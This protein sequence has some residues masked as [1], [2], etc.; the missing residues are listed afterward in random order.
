M[1]NLTLPVIDG[2]LSHNGETHPQKLVPDFDGLT[3]EQHEKDM[4]ELLLGKNLDPTPKT[5]EGCLVRFI[6]TISYIS[7]D[8][9]D[10]EILGVTG[11]DELPPLVK[12]RLGSSNREIINSLISDLIMNSIDRDYISYSLEVH[13][14]LQE[15][16]KFN[17]KKIYAHPDK[18]KPISVIRKAFRHLWDK[19]YE[20][21]IEGNTKSRIFKE[22][23]H[24]NLSEIQT[25]YPEI[26]KLEDYPYY[27]QDP[28]IIVRDFIAGMT[29]VFFWRLAKEIDPN[30]VF[31]KKKI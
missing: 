2:I 11:F 25:R 23:F 15:L 12:N 31:S 17:Y 29:D 18:L 22:H 14:A 7:R 21:L 6:D 9:R 1:Q 3:W 13:Q 30:L 19:Y 5:L 16:Y 28:K 26:R 20:D 10:A 27:H 8:I 24:L 4:G